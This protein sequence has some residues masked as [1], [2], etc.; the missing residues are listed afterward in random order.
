MDQTLGQRLRA[1]RLQCAAGPVTQVALATH[2]GMSRSGMGAWESDSHS[3]PLSEIIRMASYLGVDVR[4]LTLGDNAG[5]PEAFS[6]PEMRWLHG[7]DS[8]ETV[9]RWAV[10]HNWL[11]GEVRSLDAD[12]VVAW[13]I[14]DASMAPQYLA[15][16]RL[17]V[18]RSI[19]TV[20]GDGPYLIWNGIG[21]TACRVTGIPVHPD[22][23][24]M[25]TLRVL[26]PHVPA[27]EI[28]ATTLRVPGKVRGLF[29]AG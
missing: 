9:S 27:R 2:T 19:N 29:R 17:P 5:S 4:W 24:A 12:K 7:P 22:T 1:S 21:A 3:P 10:P 8:V 23:K 26:D 20:A 15:N 11:R 16:D 14:R 6:I 13:S 28:A 25:V 18:D